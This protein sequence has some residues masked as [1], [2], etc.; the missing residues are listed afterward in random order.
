MLTGAAA[1]A[2]MRRVG[3]NMAE[4]EDRDRLE[5]AFRDPGEKVVAGFEL[6]RV[7]SHGPSDDEHE[8]EGELLM[9]RWRALHD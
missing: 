1:L 9:R 5:A 2:H 6:G 3:R 4:L 8:P 7:F